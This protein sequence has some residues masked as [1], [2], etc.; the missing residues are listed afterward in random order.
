MDNETPRP[1]IHHHGKKRNLATR[2]K[3][4]G[5]LLLVVCAGV[6]AAAYY[7]SAKELNRL[8]NSPA[9]SAD[10]EL[11]QLIEKVGTLMALPTE[12][13]T[14]ATVED[15]KKLA[16]QAFFKNAQNGDKVLMYA[17]SKK[18]ILYRPSIDKIMEVAY[19]NIQDK[20]KDA[21]PGL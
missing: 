19:L 11:S 7:H 14:I 2:L 8:K 3:V 12:K 13:P 4:F 18:A 16:G 1:V 6:A 15:T 21:A 17:A 9:V 20:T 5:V 10:Q